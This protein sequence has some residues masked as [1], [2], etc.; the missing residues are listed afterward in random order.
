M[1]SYVDYGKIAANLVRHMFF[2]RSEKAFLDF[3]RQRGERFWE[4]FVIVSWY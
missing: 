4:P 1:N 2:K 3:L